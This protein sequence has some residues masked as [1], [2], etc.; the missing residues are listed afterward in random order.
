M[1]IFVTGPDGLLGSNIV[2]ELLAQ[3]YE[4]RAMVQPGRKVKT[5]D[6]LPIEKVEG[7]L[8]NAENMRALMK[9]CQYALHGAASTA[10]W[11]DRNP[12]V[13][14]VNIEGTRNV[15]DACKANGIERLVYIGTA[16]TFGYGT[17]EKPGTENDAYKA[18]EF[19][20]DY[21]DSKYEAH[22]LVMQYVKDGLNAVVVNPTF[23][24]GPFDS[25]PSSGAMILAVYHQ[26]VPG[27]APGGKNYICVKDAAKA[28]VNAI[29]MGR[30]GES[31]ILGNENLNF[32]EA[33]EKIAHA[34]GVKAPKRRVPKFALLLYGRFGSM[35][36]SLRK[37]AP[38]VS[39]TMAKISCAEFYYS[40]EKAQKEIGLPQTPIEDGIREA[41]DW[42]RENG[43]LK[44]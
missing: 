43:Y 36:A 6:G 27:Y 38:Q 17:K 22:Q 20:N 19:A 7:D 10:M 44:K 39:Y 16:N 40:S 2:R 5:L 26:Q 35:M 14:K 18:H 23:M 3:G 24:L 25:A 4:V 9:G 41:M 13:R 12:M 42:F 34:C 15:L 1:K 29:K 11:P 28:A 8:L 30:T 32:K 21:M 31:Y 33:F 37:K